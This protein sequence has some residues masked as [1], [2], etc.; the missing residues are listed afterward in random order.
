MKS[1][2]GTPYSRPTNPPSKAYR[3]DNI[4]IDVYQR[5]HGYEVYQKN[6][7]APY[8][9]MALNTL[10]MNNFFKMITMAGFTEV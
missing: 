8:Q 10:E 2:S 3:K 5:M 1:Q 6:G 9:R 4:T 7:D